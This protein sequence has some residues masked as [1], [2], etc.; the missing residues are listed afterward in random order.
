MPGKFYPY[1]GQF[2]GWLWQQAASWIWG[3]GLF[4]NMQVCSVCPSLVCLSICGNIRYA[5]R[6]KMKTSHSLERLPPFS[7]PLLSETYDKKTAS[8]R[9]FPSPRPLR[10]LA[11][12]TLITS[13]DLTAGWGRQGSQKWTPSCCPMLAWLLWAWVWI[14]LDSVHFA[15]VY[16]VAPE[17]AGLRSSPPTCPCLCQGF[18]CVLARTGIWGTELKLAALLGSPVLPF[19]LSSHFLRGASW[20]LAFLF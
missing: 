4:Q 9:T 11:S 12:P 19:Q 8:I 7:L 2:A 18:T 10:S 14:F 13:W 15:Q 3:Y 1:S 5:S 17:A 20:S 16:I 6:A